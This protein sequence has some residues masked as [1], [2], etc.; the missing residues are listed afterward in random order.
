MA[1]VAGHISA[2]D[3]TS[4]GYS[5]AFSSA[6]LMAVVY[7][8]VHVVNVSLWH[9]DDNYTDF[10]GRKGIHLTLVIIM[11]LAYLHRHG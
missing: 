4:N 9:C 2:Q 7:L 10:L 1:R 5:V 6:F 3:C 8:L 11:Q